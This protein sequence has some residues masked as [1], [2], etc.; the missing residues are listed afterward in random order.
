VNTKTFDVNESFSYSRDVF[1]DHTQVESTMIKNELKQI[2]M[3]IINAG[4]T[5]V[6]ENKNN[7]LFQIGYISY[8]TISYES[9]LRLKDERWFNDEIINFY[10]VILGKKFQKHWFF[11]TFFFE[12]LSKNSY[13]TVKRYTKN[14]DIFKN[15]KVFIPINYVKSH[16]ALAVINFKDKRYEYYDSLL[17]KE[18]EHYCENIFKHLR[19]YIH[20]E[21]TTKKLK[22]YD[23][24]DFTYYIPKDIP[25]QTDGY[26]CGTFINL[27]KV[28]I[29]VFIKNF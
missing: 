20:E 26:N 2:D 13:E 23:D 14:V 21:S 11:T 28:F 15:E 16:W 9:I 4:W 18:S 19:V 6:D 1:F 22:K 8:E 17:N 10:M 27:K 3:K 24:S 12:K 25:Q 7:E 5:Y 29:V